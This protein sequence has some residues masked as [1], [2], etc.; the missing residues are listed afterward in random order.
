MSLI[1]FVRQHEPLLLVEDSAPVSSIIDRMIDERFGAALIIGPDSKIIGIFT[2]RDVMSKIVRPG[3]DPAATPVSQ[4]MTTDVVTIDQ[5][6]SIDAAIHCMQAYQV[7]HLPVL[8]LDGRVVDILTVRRLL[9][10]KIKDLLEGLQ[11]FE[12]YFNDSLG[13]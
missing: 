9:H 1:R 6:Q 11:N 10:D 5:E 8:S 7:S 2:E 13:G 4:V 3:L 12:A